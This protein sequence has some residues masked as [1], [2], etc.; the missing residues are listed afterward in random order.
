[1]KEQVNS[2]IVIVGSLRLPSSIQPINLRGWNG[3]GV[4]QLLVQ[5]LE[6]LL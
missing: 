6:E 3:G 1:M 4:A 5:S 2:I